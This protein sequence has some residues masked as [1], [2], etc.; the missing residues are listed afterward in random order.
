VRPSPIEGLGLFARVPLPAGVVVSRFGGRLVGA[1]E[2][3]DLIA[4]PTTGYVDTVAFAAGVHPVLPPD[5]PNGKGN[6]SCDPNLWWTGTCELSTRREVAAGEELTVDYATLTD[7][8]DF[9]LDCTCGA[10][11]CRGTVTGRDWSRP[12]VRER[13][14]THW[15]AALLDRMA[16][17]PS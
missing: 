6:H 10:A 1:A 12:D 8:A 14:G 17:A 13:Y 15:S 2:L 9:T 11:T 16:N 3:A 7:D 5:T 4:D